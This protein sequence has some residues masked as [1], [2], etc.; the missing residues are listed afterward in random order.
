MSGALAGATYEA[1]GIT[2]RPAYAFAPP[3]AIFEIGPPASG[4]VFDIRDFGA[5]ADPAVNNQ[6]MIQAAIRAAHDAG[7]GIV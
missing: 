4:P 3:A 2:A 1:E 6:P 7:G 5:V